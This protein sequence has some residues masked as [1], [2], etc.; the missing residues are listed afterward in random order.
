MLEMARIVD[1]MRYSKSCVW[2]SMTDSERL[3]IIRHHV[4]KAQGLLAEVPRGEADDAFALK[5]LVRVLKHHLS[6][7]ELKRALSVPHGKSKIEQAD[8][9]PKAPAKKRQAI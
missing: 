3:R 6:H 9:Q 8:A 5:K 4:G 7:G 1:P 2:S